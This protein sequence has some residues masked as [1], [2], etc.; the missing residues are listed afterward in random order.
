MTEGDSPGLGGIDEIM[1][2][3]IKPL[4]D[5]AMHQYLGVTVDEIRADISDRLKTIPFFDANL[6]TD[7]PFKKAKDLMRAE[8]LTRLLRQHFGN[9]SIA[10][11]IAGLDR[12]SMHRLISRHKIDVHRFREEM[13]KRSYLKE[14]A[15]TS[16]IEKTI[17][18][19]KPG[20]NKDRVDTFYG[21]LPD[22][23]KHIVELLPDRFMTLT[24]A[25]QN[26]EKRY[27]TYHL[28]QQGWNISATARKIGLRYETL[29]RK[30]KELEIKAL[31]R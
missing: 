11:G 15:V 27:I 9:V 7:K 26:W 10:A 20:L 3:K 14:M 6:H 30:M 19:Y 13:T 28:E 21:N 23:S 18:A 17:S 25:E 22:L 4:L 8:F 2:H 29:H 16:M 5:Q 24:E 12:R 31:P 1:D